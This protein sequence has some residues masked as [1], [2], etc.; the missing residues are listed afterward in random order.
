[1]LTKQLLDTT[2]GR[3][4]TMLRARPLT[5]DEVA[6]GLG[7]T[8]NAVRSQLT[9]MERDGLV[10]RAG[11]RRGTTRPS[12]VFELT[13]EVEQLVSRA[14]VP[15]LSQP[16]Q[17]F[18][19]N[20]Q[21]AELHA[22]LRETG[23]ALAAALLAGR[24]AAGSLRARVTFAS[25]LLNDELG[26]LTHVEKNGSFVIRGAGCPLSALT[27]KHAGVCLAMESL[28]STVVGEP[29]HECCDRDGRPRCCFE[30]EQRR[31]IG[32]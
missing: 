19:A 11:Q 15:L 32:G 13:S 8:A 2:R 16:V 6:T 18:A 28:V 12:H 26:A 24:P 22:M 7:L 31:A 20:L 5:V 4:V 21:V 23:R 29:V 1:M 25:E 3:I 10:R 9:G 30:I 17:T 14:Y 27:G